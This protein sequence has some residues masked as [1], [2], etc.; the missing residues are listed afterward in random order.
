MSS[1]V[2]A[3]NKTKNILFIGEGIQLTAEKKVFN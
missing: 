3:N 1:S 2:L